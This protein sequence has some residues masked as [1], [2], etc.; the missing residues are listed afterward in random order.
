[1]NNFRI[2]EIINGNTVRVSPG[3]IIANGL[4]NEERTGNEIRI[5]G[6]DSH[7]DD[8]YAVLRLSSFILHKEVELSN[9]ELI[10]NPLPVDGIVLCTVLIDKTDIVYYFPEFN[11]KNKGAL[12][13]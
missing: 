3:W 12:A 10:E 11:K 6:L 1:M 8:K 4:D 13:V 9:P 5:K 2:T 7:P